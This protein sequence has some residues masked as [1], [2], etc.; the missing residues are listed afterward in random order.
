MIYSDGVHDFQLPRLTM[1]LQE[2][3]E[4]A[5]RADTLKE[6][7]EAK[8]AL[9]TAALGSDYV[10]ARCGASAPEDVDVA[11]LNAL[12]LDVSLAYGMNGIREVEAA[13]SQIA[14]LLDQIERVNR[15][16][17]AGGSRQGFRNVL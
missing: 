4:A 11:E 3:Y 6:A 14:P 2:R 9:M 17:G 7:V 10:E 8:L 5:R 1:A 12:F 13:L 15:I 16:T